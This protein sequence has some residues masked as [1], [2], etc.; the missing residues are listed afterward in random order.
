ML[1]LFNLMED[2]GRKRRMY[3]LETF[4]SLYGLFEGEAEGGVKK[5]RPEM[6]MLSCV[7]ER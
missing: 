4:L 3:L 6:M 1:L 2:V 7:M 5:P